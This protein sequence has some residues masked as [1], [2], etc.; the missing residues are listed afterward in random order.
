PSTPSR[1]SRSWLPVPTSA[2]P[3]TP[4]TMPDPPCFLRT[5]S[6]TSLQQPLQFFRRHRPYD[7]SP[8]SSTSRC[9]PQL[10]VP[11]PLPRPINYFDLTRIEQVTRSPLLDF[12]QPQLEGFILVHHLPQT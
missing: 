9:L 8:A 4:G 1:S 3:T 7:R 2:S 5:C 12:L 10:L 11:L 6:S